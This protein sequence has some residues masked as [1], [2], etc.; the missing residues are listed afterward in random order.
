VR[1][2]ETVTKKKLHAGYCT[3]TTGR[4]ASQQY[5]ILLHRIL[6]SK[7]FGSDVV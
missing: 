4:C 7:T 3:V 2:P 1:N 5:R 6:H